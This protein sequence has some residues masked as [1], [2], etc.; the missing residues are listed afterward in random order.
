MAKIAGNS[1]IK[2]NNKFSQIYNPSTGHYI[3][4]DLESGLIL[5]IKSDGKPF[6][7]IRLERSYIKA[8]PSIKKST[9][10]KAELAVIKLKNAKIA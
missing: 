10:N 7:G 1:Q 8:N 4:R 6:K 3:K 5:E 2:T 9:A